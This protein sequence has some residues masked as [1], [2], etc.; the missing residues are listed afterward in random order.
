M[1]Q[2]LHEEREGV[3]I[4]TLL[5]DAPKQGVFEWLQLPKWSSTIRLTNDTSYQRANLSNFEL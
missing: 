3:H 4:D 2:C 5:K 1:P